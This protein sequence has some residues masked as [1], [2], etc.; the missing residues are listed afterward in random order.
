[1]KILLSVLLSF[2]ACSSLAV[3]ISCSKQELELSKKNLRALNVA[4]N[5]INA[6][7]ASY[8]VTFPEVLKGYEL[9][10]SLL[11]IGSKER[12]SLLTQLEMAREESGYSVFVSKNPDFEQPVSVSVIYGRCLSQTI[13]LP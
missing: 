7:E 8:T 9:S 5:K 3:D 13:Q 10:Q 2:F 1:M 12:W 11:I 6:Q 4:K